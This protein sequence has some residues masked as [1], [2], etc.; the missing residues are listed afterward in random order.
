MSKSAY[1]LPNSVIPSTVS[2]NNI[3]AGPVSG[4]PA[5]AA[6]RATVAEDLATGT[7]TS[8]LVPVSAGAGLAPAWGNASGAP[9]LLGSQ[10]ASAS[11]SLTFANLITSKFDTYLVTITNLIPTTSGGL[12]Y[13]QF[14]S[15]N[16][17][18]WDTGSNYT[19]A[20]LRSSAAGSAS[21]GNGIITVIDL[22]LSGVQTNSATT[23]GFCGTFYIYGPLNSALN[24]Q[25]VGDFRSNDGSASPNV[26]TMMTGSHAFGADNAFQIFSSVGNLT[27]GI[28]R[29]YGMPK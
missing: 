20:G 22:S 7:A 8:G 2:A 3:F 9:V 13:L 12:I 24:T 1:P 15:N 29:V 5:A 16:G 11:A 17:S 27:S 19:N 23:G 28:I 4:I 25:I 21:G 26:R 10:T 6:F 14:S 18:T